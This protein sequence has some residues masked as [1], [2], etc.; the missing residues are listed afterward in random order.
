MENEFMMI[1][2]LVES[3]ARILAGNNILWKLSMPL[4]YFVNHLQLYRK[5]IET[6][7]IKRPLYADEIETILGKP[8]VKN[9]PFAGLTYPSYISYGSALYPKI[10]GSYEAELHAI[11]DIELSKHYDEIFDIGCAEGYYAVGLALKL[12]DTLIQAYDINEKAAGYCKEMSILNNVSDRIQI[13]S[14]FK[15]EMFQ[16]FNP[17]KN[18]LFICDCEG[19]ENDL[20]SK[21][22]IPYLKN[23]T[24]L[25]ETHDFII[26]G[27]SDRLEL[28]FNDTHDIKMIQ[29]IDDI[30][31]TKTYRYKEIDNV[32]QTIKRIILQESRPHIMEWL[33]ATPKKYSI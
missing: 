33:Y 24:L 23:V 2:K 19:Y 32:D 11:F 6:K 10:L 18:I 25:I 28:L 3:L 7:T 15:A 4:Q 1:K 12:P 31:K 22:I 26:P 13:H 5:Q 29:S 14:A 8:I 17:E 16:S 27:T 21:E 20:F 9:G 30:I